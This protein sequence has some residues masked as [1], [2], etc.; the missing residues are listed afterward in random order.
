MEKL[1]KTAKGLDTFFKIAYRL[2]IAAMVLGSLIILFVWWLYLGDPDILDLLRFDL[3]FG[4]ISF[5]LADSVVPAREYVFWYFLLGTLIGGAQLPV[6]CMVFHT[7]RGILKPMKEGKPFDENIADYLKR[8]GWLTIANGVLAELGELVV[9][10]NLLPG[11][12]LGALFLSDQITQVTTSHS[13]DATFLV[14]AVVLFLLSYV[15][16]YGTEL[17]QL[18]DET[19]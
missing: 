4:N 12:D 3:D 17:Q 8:L 13:F 2:G 6:F 11:Y 5:R 1:K 9:T 10:G 18:S 7:I 19:L 15:F 16:R 14:Y